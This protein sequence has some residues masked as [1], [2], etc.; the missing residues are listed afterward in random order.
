MVLPSR[1]SV[2]QS[3]RF[4]GSQ[5]LGVEQRFK[6][7]LENELQMKVFHDPRRDTE[8]LARHGIVLRGLFDTQIGHWLLRAQCAP[9]DYQR[10]LDTVLQ[11]W[12]QAGAPRSAPGSDPMTTMR[13]Q[14]WH[15][16]PHAWAQRPLPDYV[17]EYAALDVHD[18]PALFEAMKQQA[19]NQQFATI[20]KRSCCPRATPSDIALEFHGYLEASPRV[21]ASCDDPEVFKSTWQA[22]KGGE[23]VTGTASVI[24]SALVN[25][26]CASRIG[27]TLAFAE[28]SSRGVGV[29]H[30]S[31]STSQRQALKEAADEAQVHADE[32][33]VTAQQLVRLAKGRGRGQCRGRGRG[34]GSGVGA[35]VNGVGQEE[36]ETATHMVLL[37]VRYH[38]WTAADE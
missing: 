15:R 29:E 25:L 38:S 35:W 24:L 34:R 16:A 9:C 7:L 20:V 23:A 14:R 28:E 33:G 19:T 31:S 5:H 26:K 27:E 32:G 1:L 11:V 21:R 37:P 6:S 36:D 18:L 30:T 10:A 22:W 8:T 2:C 13:M 4:C 12:L 17:L 3:R